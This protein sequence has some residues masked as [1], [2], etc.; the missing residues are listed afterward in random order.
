MIKL[1]EAV[2]VEGKYDKIKLSNFIDATIIATNGFSVFKDSQ[3]RRLIKLLAEKNGIIVITDSDSAGMVIRSYIKKICGENSIKNVYI[4]QI[5]GKEKRKNSPSKEGFLGVEGIDD[6]IITEALNK[7]GILTEN[8]ERKV[9]IT[10]Q[11]LF[12]CGLSG[13]TDSRIKRE[14]FAL[15]SGLPKGMSSSAFLDALNAVYGY[16]EFL[17]AVE[18]WLKEQVK[19]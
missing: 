9:P 7:C 15:F 2:I 4:P 1:K 11:D 3:K 18:I 10:K 8:C 16:D 17:K 19:K 5:S 14:E 12:K 6:S 13:Q